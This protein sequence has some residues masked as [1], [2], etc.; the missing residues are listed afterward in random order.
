MT[1]PTPAQLLQIAIEE[2][3]RRKAA[4]TRAG[5]IATDQ[6]GEDDIIWSNI[7]HYARVLNGDR[8]RPITWH[9]DDKALMIENVQATLRKALATFDGTPQI[10]KARGLR[11]LLFALEQP[12]LYTL[13]HPVPVQPQRTAA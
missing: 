13:E 4:W 7:V 12:L 10:A 3:D 2:R 8:R 11:D 6:A 9:P 5:K 1:R